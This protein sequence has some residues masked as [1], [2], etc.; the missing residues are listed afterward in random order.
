MAHIFRV[1]DR[2]QIL[3]IVGVPEGCS[4]VE[5]RGHISDHIHR[6]IGVQRERRGAGVFK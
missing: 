4:D 1:R 6:V 5:R 2:H 3:G